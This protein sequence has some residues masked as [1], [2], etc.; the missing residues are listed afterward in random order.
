MS[1]KRLLIIIGIVVAVVVIAVVLDTTLANHRPAITGL[2][3]EPERVVPRGTCQITCNATDADDDELTYGWSAH[4]GTISG[5][6]ATVTWTAPSAVGS[7]NITVIVTDGRGDA[8]TDYL[9]ITV[10]TNRA[11]TISSLTA[12]AYWTLPSGSLNLTCVA[13]DPDGDELSYEWSSSG[14]DVSGT[15]AV[16]KWIAPEEAGI[17]DITVVVSDDYGR[18][19]T[20]VLPISVAS[21]QPPT[22][23]ELLITTDR[24]GHCYLKPYAGGYYVGKEQMYDIECVVAD[25]GI[26]LVYEWSC[27]GGELS[28]D[29]SMVTWTAPNT[30]GK[31]TVTVI[32][33]DIAGKMASKDLVL[34]VVS[35]STCTFGSC[36]TG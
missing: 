14:G 16:A 25:T 10:R 12:D 8:A 5:E 29:G 28:G 7:Y 27:T 15:G 21:E 34:N 22:I 2:E 13:S 32:V 11:P 20:K 17:Y 3:A 24:Y 30:V 6:G 33:S 4:D 9:T 31:V 35:C 19:D 1:K 23:E 26:E 36:S 18:S